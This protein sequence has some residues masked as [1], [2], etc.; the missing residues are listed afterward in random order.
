MGCVGSADRAYRHRHLVWLAASAAFFVPGYLRGGGNHPTGD[1]LFFKVGAFV[2]S[3]TAP[4]PSAG[5]LHLYAETPAVQIGPPALA[6][7]AVV[8]TILSPAAA[9]LL[10][11][12]VMA[13]AAA[14]VPAIVAAAA[15]PPTCVV[16]RPGTTVASGALVAAAWG[17]AAGAWR[18]LDDSLALVLL[19]VAV[20]LLSRSAAPWL[21]A[22]AIGL[23]IAT[24]PWLVVVSPVL[25][26]L[27][28]PSWPR[29][30][31]VAMGLALTCWLPFFLG[32]TATV[33]ALGHFHVVPA[34]GSVLSAVG[35]R[36]DVSG[37]LRLTQFSLG[38]AAACWAARR[39]DWRAAPLAG[40]AVR[41]LTDPYTWSYYGMGPL[42]AALLVD[43]GVLRRWPVLTPV[44]V[45][46]LYGLPT[47]GPGAGAAG[48]V[49]WVLAVA[50]VLVHRQRRNR[51]SVP[52]PAVPA[53]AAG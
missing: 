7:L 46:L 39:V 32:D 26:V 19:A 50:G 53:A 22:L 6:L 9:S 31:V 20:L 45:L 16:R 13:V 17:C 15:R 41:V 3:G 10:L 8:Q 43:L 36:E 35:L 28:R 18:H 27:P 51:P 23:A 2:L 30:A 37:W 4:F 14:A 25:L 40:L 24:K 33:A 47:L 52:V 49:T 44:T 11:G 29:A 38:T 1:W 5:P 42:L 34:P 12:V 48:R 21:P